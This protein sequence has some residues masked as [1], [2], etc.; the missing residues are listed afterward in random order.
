MKL[1]IKGLMEKT[2]IAKTVIPFTSKLGMPLD[3]IW[4]RLGTMTGNTAY[5][6]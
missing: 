4:P 6:S 2:L 3:I 1:A 5:L